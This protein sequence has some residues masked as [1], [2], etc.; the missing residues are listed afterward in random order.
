M[1]NFLFLF[2][3][4]LLL[5]II[6][7]ILNIIAISNKNNLKEKPFTLNKEQFQKAKE[8][9]EKKNP[10]KKVKITFWHNLY[11]KEGEVLKKIIKKF[12][13]DH[14]GIEVLADNK[15]NWGQI[16]KHVSNALT[17]DK[18]PNLVVSYPDHVGFYHK[19]NKVL[20]LDD[21]IKEDEDFQDDLKKNNFLKCYFEEIQIEN[22]E[23]KHYY[24]PFLK[25]TEIMFYNKDLLK[26]AGPI[27]NKSNNELLVDE[28]GKIK[29]DSLTWKEMD[30][31]SEQLKVSNPKDFIPIVVDSESN[32]FIIS[33]KQKGITYPITKKETEQFLK[34]PQVKNLLKDFK[35]KYDQKYFT[36]GKLTG[37]E[38]KVPE[39]IMKNNIAFYITSTRRLDTLCIKND[40]IPKLGYTNI[41]TFD[42]KSNQN[43]LQ[44]S[45]VNLFYSQNKDEMLA[46]WFF[47]KYLTSTDVYKEF[48][49]ENKFFNIKRKNEID[50]I[51][52]YIKDEKSNEETES[53]KAFFKA[54]S[55]D[56]ISKNAE[57]DNFFTTS[58][59][60]NSD[61][62]RNIIA[63]L[64]IDILTI[65]KDVEDV[66]K[67]KRIEEL[68][69]E[70]IQRILTN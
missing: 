69:N 53:K 2:S 8:D 15:G 51:D 10:S 5:F 11:D 24:L 31:I 46:S 20:P 41:P 47:L 58:I 17:V 68:L 54:F 67:A 6:T 9:F 61:F 33:T 14:P 66:N 50:K 19:S 39:L 22:D 52:D 55:K 56:F 42:D 13:T 27:R 65:D 12:E 44:G 45:N 30:E 7:C 70:A 25:T 60:E 62:F 57:K 34:E 32:L 23:P 26:T 37:E 29:K 1:K 36:L 49:Q 3:Y 64:F 28:E 40:F 35:E 4:F 18:Q 48:L 59:F 43:I 63:D 16:F 38:D 21:F